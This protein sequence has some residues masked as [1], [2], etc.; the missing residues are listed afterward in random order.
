MLRQLNAKQ[1]RQLEI[2]DVF[3]VLEDPVL[4]VCMC[5]DNDALVLF[6]NNLQ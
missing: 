3:S 5:G 1:V 2:T 6:L 4:L